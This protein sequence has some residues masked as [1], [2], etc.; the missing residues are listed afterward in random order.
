MLDIKTT[1]RKLSIKIT[2]IVFV[3]FVLTFC[4]L[5]F[6]H[7]YKF[8]YEEK[9]HLLETVT[10][11][12]SDKNFFD[13]LVENSCQWKCDKMKLITRDFLVTKAGEVILSNWV[14]EMIDLEA[15]L[16]NNYTY[17]KLSQIHLG[18]WKDFYVI[19]E[20]HNW[21]DLYFT[22]DMSF[23]MDYEKSLIYIFIILSIFLSIFIYLFSWKLARISLEPLKTYNESLKLYNHHIAHELKTPLAVI[24]SELELLKLWYDKKIV[25]SGIEEVDNMTTVI[26]SMLFLSENIILQEVKD[27]NLTEL[28]DEQ[29]E[30]YNWKNTK[31]IIKKW[32]FTND[33][34][35]SWDK[36]TL[37]TMLK[38][39]FENAVKYSKD[40]KIEIILNKTSFEISNTF[41]WVI[42]EEEKNNLFDAFY[43]L[44][45]NVDSYWLGLS[46]VKKIAVLHRFKVEIDIKENIFKIQINFR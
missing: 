37:K 38:N 41:D 21:Y 12:K 45:Y 5:I 18:E 10:F 27:I 3:F 7:H 30:Y 23:H 25:N 40:D 4:S 13:N 20:F 28:I 6:L 9:Q 43:K 19:K 39:L 2:L 35:I 16:K 32:I 36:V 1:T 15:F 22:R 11:V 31:H 26:D 8:L 44:N 14:Y 42:K 29:I 46:I 33:V 34:I 24:K 17:W